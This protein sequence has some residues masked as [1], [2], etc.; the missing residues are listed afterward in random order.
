MRSGVAASW[1]LLACMVGL[2]AFAVVVP[3]GCGPTPDEGAGT[4]GAVSAGD[5]GLGGCPPTIPPAGSSC[6]DDALICDYPSSPC[7]MRAVCSESYG[8][9]YGELVWSYGAALEGTA[10]S[11]P[12]QLCSFPS[13]GMDSITDHT[14]ALCTADG[15]ITGECIC[16]DGACATCPGSL[17]AEGDPCEVTTPNYPGPLEYCCAYVVERPCGY[18]LAYLHCD[19]GAFTVSTVGCQ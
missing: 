15:W 9:D 18:V 10:C 16:D 7:S 12:G 17:P 8:E 19:A 14:S 4:G 6:S 5:A 1:V 11:H 2:G 13:P 3:T